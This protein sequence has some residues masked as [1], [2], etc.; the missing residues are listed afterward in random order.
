MDMKVL[1]VDDEKLSLKTLSFYMGKLGYKVLQAENGQDALQIW[2]TESPRIV[3]TDWN[4]PKMDGAELCRCIR[5]ED[6]D[7]TYIIFIT[8]RE[9]IS[10]LLIGFEAG[11]DDY[12]TKPVI[13]DEL[14]VRVKA[15]ERIFLLRDK[16]MVIYALAKLT[17]ARDSE[18]GCHL[19]RIQGFA[20]LIAEELSKKPELFPEVNR[21]Y[22]E[23]I[24]TTSVLHDIGKVGIPDRILLKPGKLTPEEFAIMQTHSTIGYEA[25]NSVYQKKPNA[26]YLRI[27]AE[28]ALS[29]HERWDGSGYPN[30]LSGTNIP[31][32]ARII[33]VAD[34][35]DAL[36]SKRVYK[37]PFSHEKS[38]SL[39]IDGKGRQFDPDIVDAFLEVEADVLRVAQR[40]SD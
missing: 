32:S 23:I 4:M 24:H 9:D 29:H 3:L 31:L 2:R 7:Y 14:T 28:I 33:A 18:T 39:I 26:A 40:Y 27:A 25:L 34:V 36:I 30:R 10:D 16:E 38:M 1:I 22:I 17:E 8:S 21:Q 6:S 13:K 12:L 20:K 35:Y 19:E 15:A 37:G 5:R 11:A